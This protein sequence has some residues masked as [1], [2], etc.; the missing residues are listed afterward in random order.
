MIGAAADLV[1]P[2]GL[3]SVV[4]CSLEPEENSEIVARFLAE[5]RE[6]GT[7]D[8]E[9]QLPPP[10]RRDLIGGGQWQV[11][12]GDVHDGFTVNVVCRQQ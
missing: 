8:M 4:T 12:P 9:N 6:F 10:L 7:F 3:L 1:R 11:L 5:N 2:G